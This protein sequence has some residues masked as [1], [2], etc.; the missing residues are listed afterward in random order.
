MMEFSPQ[1]E[2]ESVC[3]LVN[4]S[5]SPPSEAYEDHHGQ[6][7]EHN[8]HGNH[9]VHQIWKNHDLDLGLEIEV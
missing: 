3:L 5:F 9:E 1:Q 8:Q 7:H 6:A 2:T 4:Q